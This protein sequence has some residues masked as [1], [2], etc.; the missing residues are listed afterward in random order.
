MLRPSTLV[1]PRDGRNVRYFLDHS[2]SRCSLRT[3]V[4]QQTQRF[5]RRLK[6]DLSKNDRT[7]L[8]EALTGPQDDQPGK[9]RRKKRHSSQGETDDEYSAVS[10]VRILYRDFL[11]LLIAEQ[12]KSLG[13]NWIRHYEICLTLG[14]FS[15]FRRSNFSE[16]SCYCSRDRCR[17]RRPRGRDNPVAAT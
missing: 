8:V 13:E 6:L 12:V 2:N 16:V 9:R 1:R 17:G 11:E 5:L 3:L 14:Y 15:L 10:G 7:A 4:M